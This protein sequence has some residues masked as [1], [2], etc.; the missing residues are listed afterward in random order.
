MSGPCMPHRLPRRRSLWAK[1]AALLAL[2]LA[3]ETAASLVVLVAT[4]VFAAGADSVNQ[5]IDRE[6][7]DA[8]QEVSADFEA[9]TVG[10]IELARALGP[11]LDQELARLGAVSADLAG[12]PD[13]LE[14]MLRAAVDPLLGALN[15]YP[16]SGAFLILD[17]TVSPEL[18]RSQ[19]SRA[20]LFLRSAEPNTV[21]R[22]NSSI[23]Y[24]RGPMSLAR[25]WAIPVL[26][27]W[28]MEIQ[29]TP[30]DYFHQALAAVGSARDVSRMYTWQPRQRLP[31]D[32]TDVM[33]LTVP[34]LA[35]DG[36]ALGVC[37]LEVSAMLFKLRHR[38]DAP[39]C[40]EVL[41]VLSVATSRD[42][43]DTSAAMITGGPY[44]ELDTGQ[45]TLV[46]Q[47]RGLGEWE[48]RR[49]YMGKVE[50]FDLYPRNSANAEGGWQLG[51]L[52]PKVAM[53][54]FIHGRN[55]RL[56]WPLVGATTLVL[57]FGA[58]LIRRIVSPIGQALDE[59]RS[60]NSAP[61]T[62]IREIDD[63]FAFLAEQDAARDAAA[64]DRL[65]N[66]VG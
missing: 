66:A 46:G 22:S 5:Y 21:T 13:A 36:T 53:Q 2:L 56:I 59:I 33:L 11:Q 63:L 6:L 47:Q 29:T 65:A 24:W 14:P 28:E 7:S 61:R 25:E 27:Q 55:Q 3:G 44:A 30:G 54:R 48:G 9:L 26:P 43:I 39:A 4:G 50:A 19:D 42:G 41:I 18:A 57:A 51:V 38:P 10:G 34:V 62:K 20:G 1:L 64:R 52:V 45:L 16:A 49:S 31:G 32:D 15:L 12:R 17:A 23:H 37:G 8:V 40:Q 60:G 58:L 35:A